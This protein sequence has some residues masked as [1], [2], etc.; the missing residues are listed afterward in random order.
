MTTIDLAWFAADGERRVVDIALAL[1]GE[2]W[3]VAVADLDE[4]FDW[5]ALL[6]ASAWGEAEGVIPER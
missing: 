3:D 1:R 6:G 5:T 4:L 2:G